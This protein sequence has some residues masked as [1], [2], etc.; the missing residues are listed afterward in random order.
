MNGNT[1]MSE[2]GFWIEGSFNYYALYVISFAE[3]YDFSSYNSGYWR[4]LMVENYIIDFNA[5][6]IDAPYKYI[7]DNSIYQNYCCD[8]TY[9]NCESYE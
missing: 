8:S 4:G 9:G 3:E 1:V 6:T 2:A 7:V 5:N